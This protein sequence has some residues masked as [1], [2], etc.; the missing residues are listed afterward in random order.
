MWLT[1]LHQLL[2]PLGV[3]HNI[4]LGG[5]LSP[6]Q[7][8]GRIQLLAGLRNAALEPWL[9]PR[10]PST[11]AAAAAAAGDPGSAATGTAAV[12]GSAELSFKAGPPDSW[13]PD[14]LM[15]AN[16]VFL[17]AEDVMRLLLH[18]AHIACGMDFYDAPWMSTDSAAGELPPSN[19]TADSDGGSGSS[20]GGSG[21]SQGVL[22]GLVPDD[23]FFDPVTGRVKPLSGK[24]V[25]VGGSSS[26]SGGVA[27]G[28]GS[29]RFYDKVRVGGLYACCCMDVVARS[30]C[31]S[32]NVAPVTQH[33]AL[34][35]WCCLPC[36]CPCVATHIHTVGGAGCWGPQ[37][38][39]PPAL[40]HTPPSQP[41][42]PVSRPASANVLLLERPGRA[43]CTPL[44]SRG[45]WPAVQD[46]PPRGVPGLRVQPDV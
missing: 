27:P 42:S 8:L 33:P 35:P 30:V 40:H 15:Y 6:R 34:T 25:V 36:C 11:A 23:D 29:M 7:G 41:S 13:V 45:G 5:S 22:P 32:S 38:G 1:L 24:V 39:Q 12:A 18:R 21:S 3:P 14:V 9:P 43:G 4:T 2:L 46:G 28:G 26:G 31:N 17:C 20:E 16:D 37:V 19:S 10:Q 44:Y